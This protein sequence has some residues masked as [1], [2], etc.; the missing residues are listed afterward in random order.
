MRR[1]FKKPASILI[2]SSLVWIMAP[3]LA[4]EGAGEGGGA[5]EYVPTGEGMAAVEDTGGVAGYEGD[6][7]HME[8]VIIEGRLERPV[9]LF[10]KRQDPD[11]ATPR[12]ARS[13][14]DDILQPIDKE[15]FEKAVKETKFD[16]V[17]NPLLWVSTSTAILSGAASGYQY[18]N[19][20][21]SSGTHLAIV[22]GSA[23]AASLV[24]IIIDKARAPE[25]LR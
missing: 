24:L 4:Q 5:R 18:Y 11:F 12:F 1:S 23:A 9:G 22:C 25:V 20:E 17:K 13:F 3:A 2:V 6:V 8:E 7:L 19:G 14:W 15:E 21:K 16:F 10:L